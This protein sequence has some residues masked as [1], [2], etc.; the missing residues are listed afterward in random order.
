MSTGATDLGRLGWLLSFTVSFVIYY[1]ICL[2][3]PTRNQKLIKEMGLK[4]EEESGDIVLAPDGT[5]LI[6][7]GGIVRERSGE[8]LNGDAVVNET[9]GVEKKD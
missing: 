4:W 5:E 3:W 7:E 2:F 6:E 1:I 8:T 9:Y